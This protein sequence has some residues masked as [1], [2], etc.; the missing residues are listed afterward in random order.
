M[1]SEAH[2]RELVTLLVRDALPLL[3]DAFTA[4][5]ASRQTD[6]LAGSDIILVNPSESFDALVASIFQELGPHTPLRDSRDILQVIAEELAGALSSDSSANAVPVAFDGATRRLR[7][8]NRTFRFR[9]PISAPSIASFQMDFGG[10]AFLQL[11]D[12]SNQGEPPRMELRGSTDAPH[13]HYVIEQVERHIK[14]IAGVCIATGLAQHYYARIPRIPAVTLEG[15]PDE[16]PLDASVGALVAGLVFGVPESLDEV[17]KRRAKTAGLGE[18]LTPTLKRI[19]Y[20]L[21]SPDG[22]A[23]TLR[24]AASLFAEALAAM[25]PGRSVALALMALEALLLDKST[26]D[27]VLARLKEAV[28]YRLGGS[29]DERRELRKTVSRLYEVRSSFVHRGELPEVLSR[30]V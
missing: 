5:D 16:Y 21:T 26:T 2:L 24:S 19:A 22:P 11:R 12:Y 17:S 14:A 1:S 9:V 25:D 13:A 18:A 28:A 7:D 6:L 8:P 29:H 10:S 4:R 20:I 30:S 27:N 15:F 3:G 23:L